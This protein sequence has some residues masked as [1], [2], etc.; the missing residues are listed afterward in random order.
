MRVLAFLDGSL[1]DP[2]AA[3]LRVD[4][5]GLL[6]GDG[7]FE[8]ILVAVKKPREMRPHLDRLARSAAMLDLPDPDL[9]GFARAAQ[10]VVDAWQGGPEIALKLV[11]TRGVDGDPQGKPTAFALGLEVDEK[12]L[13][14]R[15]EGVSVVTLERGFGPE[16]AERAP[17]LLLGAKTVSYAMN[18]AALREA[19][20]RGAQDV[21]FTATDDSVLEG[22]TST[23]VLAKERTLYTPPSTI[24]ILPGTTQYALFRGAEKAGWSV[25][26]EPF[27]VDDLPR[28][29]GV[30]LTSSV[31]KV[32]RVHTLNGTALPDST[33]LHGE[34]VAAYESEY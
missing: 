18:M 28:G 19:A 3:H 13:R 2:E 4:D 6:R 29:D 10:A 31:R 12:V 8:T 14:A 30:F 15:T 32:T 26:V 17:W 11:Y 25:K 33:T 22:P 23:V 34:L 9:D 27:S 21:I 5:L 7:V 1:A 16:L 20:R 24:G